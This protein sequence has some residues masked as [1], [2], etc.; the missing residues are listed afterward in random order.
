MASCYGGGG[1]SDAP[2]GRLGAECCRYLPVTSVIAL[3]LPQGCDPDTGAPVEAVAVATAIQLDFFQTQ[4]E[5]LQ[6]LALMNAVIE[7]GLSWPFEETY[8]DL[9]AY[10]R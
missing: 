9:A 1:G 10:C 6:G 5:L 3:P 4:A 2:D 8:A 7:E